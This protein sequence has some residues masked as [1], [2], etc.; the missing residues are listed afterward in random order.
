M[1][2]LTT[3]RCITEQKTKPDEDLSD[4]VSAGPEDEGTTVF[5][6]VASYILLTRGE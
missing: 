1:L 5:R 6:N 2:E 3:P 4:T